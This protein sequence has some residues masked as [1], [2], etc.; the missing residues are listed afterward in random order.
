MQVG[1]L[2]KL[3]RVVTLGPV[4]L[5]LGLLSR[6]GERADLR[7]L[8]PWFVVAFLGLAALRAAGLAPPAAIHAAGQ[9]S[10]WLT[11]AAMAALGLGTDVRALLRAGPRVIAAASLSLLL[12]GVLALGLLALLGW[13]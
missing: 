1:A 7:R 10:I 13:A 9:V 4:C 6:G 2:V 5:A 3:T 12:L 11:V 8:V